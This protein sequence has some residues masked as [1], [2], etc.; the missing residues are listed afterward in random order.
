MKVYTTEE[1]ELIME[2]SLKW[3][4]NPN[5]SVV[6]K[7]YGLKASVQA[8]SIWIWQICAF[9]LIPLALSIFLY[10][11]CKCQCTSDRAI[12]NF[13]TAIWCSAA[14][15]SD[16]RNLAIYLM[17]RISDYWRLSW[18]ILHY[19]KN[20]CKTIRKESTYQWKND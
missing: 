8:C 19:K 1:Q 17:D 13:Y 4:G 3:A 20:L 2:P 14:C 5:I 6:V 16:I 7:A 10:F 15:N 11:T 18:R 12:E 9:F